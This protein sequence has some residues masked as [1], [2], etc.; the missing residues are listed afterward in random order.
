[1]AGMAA[2]A[3]NHSAI[4][5]TSHMTRSAIDGHFE[6]SVRIRVLC[7]CVRSRS[8]EVTWWHGGFLKRD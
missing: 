6:R 7:A 4:A 2:E 3:E 5:A 8:N 1:M